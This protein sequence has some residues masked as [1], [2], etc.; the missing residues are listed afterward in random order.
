MTQQMQMNLVSRLSLKERVEDCMASKCLSHTKNAEKI[1]EAEN[2][3]RQEQ[4]SKYSTK[5]EEYLE[6]K[7][8]SVESVIAVMDAEQCLKQCQRGRDVIAK[9]LE[10]NLQEFYS[11]IQQCYKDQEKVSN[12]QKEVNYQGV[13]GCLEDNIE[14]LKVMDKRLNDEFI[15]RQ[16]QL[17]F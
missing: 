17:F 10:Q 2:K 1:I 12:G 16:E 15:M 13:V 5:P 4:K 8:S 11:N 7:F 3:K 9:T 14:I 6:H